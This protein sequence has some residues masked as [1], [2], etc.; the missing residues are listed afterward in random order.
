MWFLS[1]MSILKP[2]I[3]VIVTVFNL[4]SYVEKCIYSICNQSYSNIEIICVNDG[5]TDDSHNIINKLAINDPRIVCLDIDNSG[6]TKARYYGVK[7][8]T[9][10]FIIF[11]DGDD[12]LPEK[13]IDFLVDKLNENNSD[14]CI[15]GYSAIYTNKI[16]KD[17]KYIEETVLPEDLAN[18]LILGTIMGSPC[19]RVYKKSLFKNSSFLFSRDIIRGEDLLMNIELLGRAKSISVTNEIVYNYHIRGS[20]TMGRFRCSLDYEI[21]FRKLIRDLFIKNNFNNSKSEDALNLSDL[22]AY[23]YAMYSN[24]YNNIDENK[25]IIS[26]INEHEDILINKWK[27]K[28]KFKLFFCLFGRSYFNQ[29]ILSNF[30]GIIR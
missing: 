11:V 18:K 15:G 10:E 29:K 22:N 6:V 23:I 24:L 28:V 9:S 12:T 21:K 7:N 5:S 16:K 26:Y 2:K 8:A 20:S 1:N 17:F 30:F 13:S 3:S 4:E 19:M 27:L 25:K 14:I